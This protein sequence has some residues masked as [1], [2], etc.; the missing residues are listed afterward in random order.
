[1]F[2]MTLF[3]FLLSTA[4]WSYSIAYVVDRIQAAFV[5]DSVGLSPHDRVSKYSP[6]FN[7]LVLV[8]VCDFLRFSFCVKG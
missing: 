5:V 1:M 4:Y 2:Y 3:M 8:N 6:L 7:S